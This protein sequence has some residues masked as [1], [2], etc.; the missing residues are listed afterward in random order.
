MN[1]TNILLPIGQIG[2]AVNGIPFH[3]PFTM[4]NSIVETPTVGNLSIKD[5]V[6]IRTL[7][8]D[9]D[10]LSGKLMK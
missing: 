5:P 4:K 8:K 9:N 10:P 1:G 3:S 6:V 7:K 2:V